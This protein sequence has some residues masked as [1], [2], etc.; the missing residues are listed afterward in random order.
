MDPSGGP[1][2][3]VLAADALGSLVDALRARDYRVFAPVHDRGSLRIDEIE[4]ADQ[5]P[6]GLEDDQEPGSYRLRDGG[7]TQLFSYTVSGDGWKRLLFPPRLRLWRAERSGDG[8]TV[9]AEPQP[10]DRLAL[11]GVR[12][13]D[14][15]AIRIQ[16]RVFLEG[17]HPD[18]AYRA[19]REGAFIVA[20]NCARASA[21][22]FCASMD[23]GPRARPGYDL[24]LTE[25]V[26]GGHRFLVE[27]G[28]ERGGEL[29]SALPATAAGEPDREQAD[30]VVRATEASLVRSMPSGI[31][32]TLRAAA[33]SPRWD[34]VASRCLACT[35]CTL[36]C[37]TCF[38]TAVE[39][40]TDLVGTAERARRWDSCFT[41]AHSYLHGGSVHAG[42]A[43]RYRQWMTHK[44]STWFDQFDTPGCTGCGRC[45]TWCPVA[46]D[47]T[48]EAH[49]L[50]AEQ[51]AEARP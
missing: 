4:R 3:R 17:E 8:V 23:A 27:P 46:I 26:D 14:L 40:T 34:D 35:N 2:A 6:R 37:P 11:L 22:C 13:C 19:R 29:L 47:I 33:A 38:C 44:L 36:V 41:A 51:A 20:V 50:T 1:S 48:E 24:A 9:R 43:S 45:L 25:L 7:G 16:D 30:A 32:E 31:R 10:E 15:A 5:L 28:T 42:T 39:D 18:P 21:S 49:A 12:G